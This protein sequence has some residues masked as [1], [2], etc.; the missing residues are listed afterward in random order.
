MDFG[1][2]DNALVI[3]V[4]TYAERGGKFHDEV[5]RRMHEVLG[6]QR[7]AVLRRLGDMDA[8]FSYF[9]AGDRKI[10]IIPEGN[11]GKLKIYDTVY[12]G[13]HTRPDGTVEHETSR[14]NNYEVD[15]PNELSEVLGALATLVPEQENAQ[16]QKTKP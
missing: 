5:Q 13:Q 4:P 12:L 9:G 16:V 11:N 15:S 8:M 1:S 6:P 10:A 7:A 14:E 2:K 3:T